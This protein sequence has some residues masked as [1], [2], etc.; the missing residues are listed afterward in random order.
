[1]RS[2]SVGGALLVLSV[3]LAGCGGPAQARTSVNKTLKIDTAPPKGG[4]GSLLALNEGRLGGA[5]AKGAACLWLE[6]RGRRTQVIWPAGWAAQEHPLQVVDDNGR[7]V[8]KV[9]DFLRLTGGM[10]D[11]P[12]TYCTAKAL[13]FTA[14]W[15]AKM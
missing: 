3:L 1:M 8:A 7:V 11:S 4:S 5:A 2:R 9:G 6:N 15:V 14:S 12:A 13:V 10:S